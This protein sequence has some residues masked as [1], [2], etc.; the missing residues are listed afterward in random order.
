MKGLLGRSAPEGLL[1]PPRPFRVERA[2]R[3]SKAHRSKHQLPVEP[4]ES[5]TVPAQQRRMSP[6]RLGVAAGICEFG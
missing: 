6:D 5:E 1:D 4:G 2:G 3:P